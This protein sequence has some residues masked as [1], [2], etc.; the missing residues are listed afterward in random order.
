MQEE[1]PESSIIAT[2]ISFYDYERENHQNTIT[3]SYELN[4]F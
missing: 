3:K 2:H 4:L 1:D